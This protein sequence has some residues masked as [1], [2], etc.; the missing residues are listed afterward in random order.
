MS[1][2][3]SRIR[4]AVAL[5]LFTV[6]AGAC[7]DPTTTRFAPREKQLLLLLDID[8]E[9]DAQ[10]LFVSTFDLRP[11]EDLVAELW[12]NGSLV[13]T[14]VA[15]SLYPCRV[16]YN[17]I[18]TGITGQH[19]YC[20]VFEYRPSYGT[21]YELV[22][23]ARGRPTA[24][25]QT[26]VPGDFRVVDGALAGDPPGTEELTITWTRSE[27]SYRYLVFVTDR[28]YDPIA[29]YSGWSLATTDTAV[30]THRP[31]DQVYG[32]EDGDWVVAVYA[33]DRAL[34]DFITS[35]GTNGLFPVPP[36]S[37]MVNA[38][39]F[40]GSWVRKYVPVDSFPLP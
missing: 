1:I 31:P 15:E 11:P 10:P 24:T 28:S 8:P 29:T 16:R 7:D 38:H 30:S 9:L 13:S 36:V 17:G 32:G 39:G 40:F 35:G 27:P 37:N 3:D 21:M 5:A 22:V 19:N 14:A 25:A 2:S 18:Q 6:M 34:F 23:R 4:L 33:T 26:T 12:S 20:S